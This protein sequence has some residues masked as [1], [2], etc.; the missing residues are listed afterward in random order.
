MNTQDTRRLSPEAQEVLR[1]RVVEAVR[2]GMSQGEAVRVFGVSRTSVWTWMGRWRKGGSR[3]L[4]NGKRGRPPGKRLVGWQAGAVVR[5]VRERTPEQLKFRCML[6]TREAVQEYIRRRFKVKLS[7]WTVGR[8]LR[9]WGLSPQK[10][11]RRAFEQDPVAV[12]RWLQEEYPAIRRRAKRERAQI[13]W[14][15]QMGLRSDH[16]AGRSWGWKGKTPV[17]P[18]TGKRFGCSLISAVT[19]RGKLRFRVFR[20]RFTAQLFLDF[21]RRLVR[22]AGRLVFLI[23][24]RHPV[25]R[26]GEVDRWLDK[27]TQEIRLFFLPA[28]SPE[29]NPD[30]FLNNDVKKN[31]LG[32]CRP[33]T[34]EELESTVRSYLYSTQKCPDIVRNYFQAETVQYAAS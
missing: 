1:R 6:W 7:V 10:P 34:P 3:A 13:Y 4:A 27:H 12:A 21:L 29:L 24:D 30:E 20:K 18:G 8:Y 11:V 23:V 2:G 22:D 33:A 5:V 17:V 15:D 32:V 9:S 28:Y 26:A 19:N 14:G 16:Q 31:G 25:H